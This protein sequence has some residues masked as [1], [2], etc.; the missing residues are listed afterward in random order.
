M[1]HIPARMFKLMKS[2]IQWRYNFKFTT[3]FL[4]TILAMF[5]NNAFFFIAN[6]CL[7]QT[8]YLTIYEYTLKSQ[9]SNK[10]S[11][12]EHYVIRTQCMSLELVTHSCVYAFRPYSSVNAVRN[13]HTQFNTTWHIRPW[14]PYDGRDGW[15]WRTRYEAV[16]KCC[17]LTEAGFPFSYV[18]PL[19][20]SLHE[21]FYVVGVS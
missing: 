10:M 6:S 15:V 17:P 12:P 21:V 2:I 1:S 4:L 14:R 3:M 8:I 5:Y 16:R 18:I 13:E 11:F 19:L 9:M 7:F 20:L